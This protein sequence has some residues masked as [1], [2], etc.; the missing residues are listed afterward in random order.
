MV[1]HWLPA[2]ILEKGRETASNTGATGK[3]VCPT[4]GV[5]ALACFRK[6]AM[7]EGGSSKVKGWFQFHFLHPLCSSNFR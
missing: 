1:E 3:G 4:E 7:F 2:D 5:Q 6:S